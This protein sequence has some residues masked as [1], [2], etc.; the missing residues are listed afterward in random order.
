MK[1]V[2]LNDQR[3]GRVEDD[4]IIPFDFPGGMLGLIQAG[5]AGLAQA[6]EA[7][8]EPLSFAIEKLAAPLT[9]PSKIMA[10]GRNYTE[11]AQESKSAIPE[12][13]LLFA[14]FPTTIIG[15]GAEVTW[16]PALSDKIDFEAEL[17]V[18]IGKTARRVAEAEAL[19]YVF[20]YTCANDVTARDLQKGDG[21]WVRGKSLDTFCPLGP[22]LVTANEVPDPQDLPIRCL[23]NGQTMQDSHTGK[24]IFSVA[25]LISYLSQAFTLLPG[26]IL[27]TG[28]PDGVGA[29]REPPVFLKH[30]DVMAVEI[31]GV[32]RLVNRCR[33]E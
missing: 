28:T 7:M 24:M 15:P 12:R 26:D 27:L 19:D 6:Q 14:K 20:G 29:Y 18:I 33:T 22:W 5:E 16:N 32:G 13:P 31:D 8:G 11:H 10:I 17:A 23:V 3:L 21:Q 30:G 9:S 2:T 1:L 4:R 25:Y